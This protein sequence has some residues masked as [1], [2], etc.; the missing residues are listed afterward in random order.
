MKNI[1]F[2]RILGN[3]LKSLHGENQTL[4]N[5]AFTLKHEPDFPDTDKMFLLNRIYDKTKKNNIISLLNKYNVRYI[6]L[7]F[8]EKK[9]KK[10]RYNKSIDHHR[11]K[12]TYKVGSEYLVVTEN[13]IY[14][15]SA[16]THVAK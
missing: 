3:D 16:N 12:N 11:I 5:L 15:L 1:L 2:F 6:D 4:N 8:E 7:P 14:V 10:I 9:F 13:T